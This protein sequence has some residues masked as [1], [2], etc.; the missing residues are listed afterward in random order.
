MAR[1]CLDD[2]A[3]DLRRGVQPAHSWVGSGWSTVAPAA[4][5]VCGVDGMFAP[6]YAAP[7]LALRLGFEVDGRSISDGTRPGIAGHGLLHSGGEWRPDRVRRHGTYHHY[8]DGRLVSFRVDSTL[9][10]L[11]GEGGYVL[12]VEIHNRADSAVRVALRPELEPGGPVRVPL[13]EWGWMPPAAGDCAESVGGGVWRAGSVELRLDADRLVLDIPAG[14]S[15]SYALLV[16]IGAVGLG[17]ARFDAAGDTTARW[18]S[19]LDSVLSRVPELRTDV[20]G[21]AEYWRR[22]LASGLVCLWDNPDFVTTPFVATSG[23]DGGALCA[24]AWDTG[25]YAP[26]LLTLML[27]DTA[28][29]LLEA[30][31]KADL[32]DHY[33]IAPDGSGLGVG[34]AYTGWSLV[35]L[36]SAIACC[37]GISAG[38]VASLHD[39]VSLLDDAAPVVGELRDYGTQHN[40]L[41]MRGAGWEHVVA[42]PNAERARCLELLAELAEVSGAPLPGADLRASARRIRAAVVEELWDPEAGWFR[43]RYPDGHTEIARSIQAYDAL[44]AGAV[45]DEIAATLLAELRPG[46]FLGKYG[47]SSVSAEDERHYELGDTDWSGG[48]AY[49]GE[50][51]LLAL[52][53]W[54][55]GESALAWDVLRRLLWMG[56]HFPYFPQEHFCDRPSGPG[57]HR[58]ANIVAGLAGAEAILTGLAGIR[59]RPDGSLEFR[60]HPVEGMIELS[61]LQ[62]RGRTIDV[63]VSP[64][65]CELRV[66]GQRIGGPGTVLP[67][68]QSAL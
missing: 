50:A 61:G 59:P 33:A 13:G 38:L 46:A 68:N 11:Y 10:P 48:G 12:A 4:G 55:R 9:T 40:L 43:S 65:V 16:R 7:D 39:T 58:R 18:N 15:G 51:P 25:G 54:E 32:T 31:L 19:R 66:D 8:R 3:F 26:H 47:V 21:L 36:A 53:L 5:T 23:I 52:T 57:P 29:E 14:G 41:E 2:F 49:T 37:S 62:F 28:P 64:D 44:R 20:P 42:S 60:P 1:Y 6:P 34:Y 17:P 24:Y 56:E 45:T 30:M 22:C 67:R 27:G 63:V 35:N